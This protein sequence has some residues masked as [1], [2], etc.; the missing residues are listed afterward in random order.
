M[1][2]GLPGAVS[3]T[4]Q[5]PSTSTPCHQDAA[6]VTRA[7]AAWPLRRVEEVQ[8]AGL[9]GA[10][11][12]VID[13]PHHPAAAVIGSTDLGQD[14][15]ECHLLGHHQ[16]VFSLGAGRPASTGGVRMMTHHRGVGGGC[17]RGG[18]AGV[19]RE[20]RRGKA[21]AAGSPLG[22]RPAQVVNLSQLP[23]PK[24]CRPCRSVGW[25][26]LL[27]ARPTGPA[28]VQPWSA[29]AVSQA[30][31]LVAE[32]RGVRGPAGR[33]LGHCLGHQRPHHHGNLLG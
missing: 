13:R 33:L 10:E 15:V 25:S 31:Q 28:G 6:Q 32:A 9:A 17:G 30:Q 23:E 16:L 29:Q 11:L 22:S 20:V 8:G 1:D 21:E 26:L 24:I 14:L 7:R 4:E 3:A 2:A 12:V 27:G 19:A 5:A 18:C